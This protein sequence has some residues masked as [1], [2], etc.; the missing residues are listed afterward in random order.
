M[1][2]PVLM[3]IF[4]RKIVLSGTLGE[5]P[6][7]P[8]FHV[9]DSGSAANYRDRLACTPRETNTLEGCVGD[10]WSVGLVI[11]FES[12]SARRIQLVSGGTSLE[13]EQVDD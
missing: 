13:S 10:D 11:A 6:E 9:S 4:L 2:P 12:G 3:S 5:I 8:I 1:T 7:N